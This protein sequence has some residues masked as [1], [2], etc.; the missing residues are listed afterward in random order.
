ED[1]RTERLLSKTGRLHVGAKT[2]PGGALSRWQS[3]EHLIRAPKPRPLAS[4]QVA[5][6]GG[7]LVEH[8]LRPL[9]GFGVAPLGG[10]QIREIQISLRQR[11][12]DR[13]LPKERLSLFFLPGLRVGVSEQSGGAL[14]IVVGLFADDALQVRYRGCRVA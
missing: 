4:P 10:Q 1:R 6:H 9:A 7:F 14:E 5:G 12:R 2:A 11:R 3:F 13:Y 8:L